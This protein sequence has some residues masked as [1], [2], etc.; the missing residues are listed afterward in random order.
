MQELLLL[1]VFDMLILVCGLPGTG[2]T[3]L[4]GRIAKEYSA[5]HLNTD[6]IRRKYLKE[7]TY[8]EEEKKMIYEKLFSEAEKSLNEGKTVVLDGTFY[9]KEL[10]NK[11]TDIAE[12]FTI[13][14]CVLDEKVLK[15][16]IGKRAMCNVASEANYDVYLKVKEQ[17][18]PIEQEH[19]VLD[20]SLPEEEQIEKVNSWMKR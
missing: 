4:A 10:R 7:R 3:T 8:S 9:K 17:F 6:I 19:L 2:K 15:E 1:W 12:K 13:I 14:E 20:T 5:I 11:A 16:R 18:E